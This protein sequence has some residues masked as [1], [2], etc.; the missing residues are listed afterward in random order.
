[1]IVTGN[2]FTTIQFPFIDVAHGGTVDEIKA[3][4]QIL[5]RTVFEHQG[6]GGTLVVRGAMGISRTSTRSSS[7]G[8]W[9]SS[10]PIVFARSFDPGPR[11]SR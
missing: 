6:Q 8:T 7:I 10:S 3:L 2:I 9:W 1:M 5:E 4:N 11:S